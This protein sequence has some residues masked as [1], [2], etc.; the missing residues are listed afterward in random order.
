MKYIKPFL[1][2]LVASLCVTSV[3]HA[4]ASFTF[5]AN[6]IPQII[7]FNFLQPNG[8]KAKLLFKN[9]E[10]P[11]KFSCYF[12][13]NT[14][15]GFTASF[16][17]NHNNIAFMGNSDQILS[18]GMNDVAIFTV[19]SAKN[20]SPSGEVDIQVTHNNKRLNTTTILCMMSK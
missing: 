13:S 11:V 18:S 4:G 12:A 19:T 16:T 9:S 20:S 6:G 5:S 10:L 2:S 14:P 1:A 3:A 15:K 8:D 7:T 17:S